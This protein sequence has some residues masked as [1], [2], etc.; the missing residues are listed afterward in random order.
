MSS[1]ESVLLQVRMAMT[2]TE[3]RPA[4]LVLGPVK[5][6]GVGEAKEAYIRAC[7]LHNWQ[8]PADFS[9]I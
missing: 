8:V 4:R 2:S 1:L 5:S 9:A 3:P 6:Y 7:R